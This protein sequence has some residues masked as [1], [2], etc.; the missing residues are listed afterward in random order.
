MKKPRIAADDERLPSGLATSPRKTQLNK[1]Q[2][3]NDLVKYHSKRYKHSGHFKDDQANALTNKS[4]PYAYDYLTPSQRA[5][6]QDSIL[7]RQSD[8]A[9]Q[10]EAPERNFKSVN[11]PEI[12]STPS[13]KSV[14]L[15]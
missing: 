13:Q 14:D 1:V 3:D 9:A 12:P 11:L 2:F 8:P 7:E 5:L 6:N 10:K 4:G 15:S